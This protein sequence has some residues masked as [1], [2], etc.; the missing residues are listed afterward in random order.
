MH[1]PIHP[2]KAVLAY[3]I[4]DRLMTVPITNNNHNMLVCFQG[5]FE[6]HLRVLAIC[7]ALQNVVV[8][9]PAL[10]IAWSIRGLHALKCHPCGQVPARWRGFWPRWKPAVRCR[11][12]S[13]EARSRELEIEAALHP[14]TLQVVRDQADTF[15]N[16]VPVGSSTRRAAPAPA[17]SVSETC[18]GGNKY[19]CLHTLFSTGKQKQTFIASHI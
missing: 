17:D 12:L 19:L 6:Y 4:T 9:A 7:L 5:I 14:K 2:E 3:R 10:W 11:L 18:S 16:V 13:R 15:A 8:Y 1:W